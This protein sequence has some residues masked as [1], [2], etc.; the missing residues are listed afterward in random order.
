MKTKYAGG[1]VVIAACLWGAIGLFSRILTE[2]GM[3]AIQITTVRSLVTAIGLLIWAG[4]KGKW[5]I[6]YKDIWMFLGTGLCSVAG[7]N[8]FYFVTMTQTTLSLAA[9]L[10]Y[11][12]PFFVLLLSAICFRERLTRQKIICSILALC[13]CICTTGVLCGNLTITPLG[14]LT[15]VASGFCYALYSIFGKFALQKYRF[16]TVTLYTF[17]VAGLALLPFSHPLQ[18]AHMVTSS[19][20]VLTVSLLLGLVFTLLPFLLY[21]KGLAGI[22]SGTA[23]VLAFAEP[24]TAT[25]LGALVFREYPDLFGWLG[26]GLLFVAL[27]LLQRPQPVP[28]CQPEQTS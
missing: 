11:T 8:I 13:G 2:A 18:L 27:V 10:L 23:S 28:Q 17:L 3:N 26:V 16:E 21:T 4:M 5:R 7:F 19:P 15:G 25:L 1:L 24:L 12:A 6:S 20:T 14:I 9:V 22:S